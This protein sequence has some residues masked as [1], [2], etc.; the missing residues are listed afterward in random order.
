MGLG[1]PPPRW[2][3]PHSRP[4]KPPGREPN[5]HL[6]RRR[7]IRRSPWIPAPRH[8]EEEKK[9]QG[10]RHGHGA[11][12]KPQGILGQGGCCLLGYAGTPLLPALPSRSPLQTL[13]ISPIWSNRPQKWGLG[14]F[15]A[16]FGGCLR[17]SSPRS[18]PA[19]PPRAPNR[20]AG[21]SPARAGGQPPVLCHLAERHVAP[22]RPRGPAGGHG[23]TVGPRG[24]R[25]GEPVRPHGLR[26]PRL[27][28][29][30]LILPV[31]PVS[32]SPSSQYPIL[33]LPVSSSSSQ[34]PHPHP[35][36]PPHSRFTPTPS[37]PA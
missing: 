26:Q 32:S 12:R 21:R 20:G 34:Y 16:R 18:P 13:Q 1:N 25:D 3:I 4:A 30:V 8:C 22:P 15:A 24:E 35:P 29:S 27:P 5:L 9:G 6:P 7:S 11:A 19:R 10:E 31:S 36:S 23:V 17:C 14:A 28:P 33:I 37:H 2:Q